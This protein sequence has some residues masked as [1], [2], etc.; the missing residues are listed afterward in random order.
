MQT[1][2]PAPVVSVVI[3]NWNAAQWTPRCLASLREQTVWD[4][5][6][7]IFADNTS[8]DDSEKVARGCMAEWPSARFFQTGG[9]CGFGGGSNRAAADARGKYIFFLSPDVWLEPD[10]V[11]QLVAAGEKSG[12]AA[13]AAKVLDYADDSIQWWLDDGYDI[14]GQGV[15]APAGA[16]K[17]FSAC[18]FPF[19]RADTF[20]RLGGFDEKFFMYGEEDELAWGLWVSGG[21]VEPA[22]LARI[23]HRGE[24]AVNPKG[25]EQITEFRTSKRKRFYA[26]RNHLLT[27]L[28]YPQHIL[29]LLPVAFTAL[30]LVEGMFWLVW[31]RRWSLAKTTSFDALHECWRMRAHVFEQRRRVKTFRQRGDFWMLRFFRFRIG[32]WRDVKKMFK[33]GAPKIS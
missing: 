6:E 22:P 26:N 29:W 14:F 15:S 18:T 3:L 12:A 11:A 28:K 16:V 27:L 20:R 5:M 30:L 31:T 21:F 32:M 1:D 19:V 25:G 23:H 2:S 17:S 24:A 8:T 13:V 4:K 10:C 33:L 7:I 9:N